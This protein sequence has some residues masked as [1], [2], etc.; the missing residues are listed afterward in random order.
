[1]NDPNPSSCPSR[2]S[3][4]M[5]GGFL[6][7][8]K[9]TAMLRLAS[10]LRKRGRCVALITN[11]QSINLVDTARIG[12][13]GHKVREITGGCFCCR[14]D[15]LV[16]ASESLAAEAEPDVIIAEPVGSC[17]DLK[18]TVS[19]PLQQMHGRQYRVAP[20]SVMVDPHRAAAALRL[21]GRPSFTEMVDYIY[22]K[23]LEEAEI[24]VLNKIDAIDAAFRARLRAALSERY[25]SVPLLE[26]SCVRGD[27]LEEWF[28]RM[29]E[30]ELGHSRAMDI[31]YDTYAEGEARLG[32]VNVRATIRCPEQVDPDSLLATLASHI[33]DHVRDCDAEIGHLKLTL[34]PGHGLPPAS[35]SI[36]RNGECVQVTSVCGRPA[37]AGELLVNLRAE[38]DPA[39]L[40]EIVADSLR[41]LSGVL[42][43][44]EESAAFRPGRPTPTHRMA[45]V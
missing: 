16:N 40:H 27:G 6:G 7:A 44:V 20:L 4:V 14:F 21:D 2:I 42:T 33:H 31:D 45:N 41:S 3:Y 36:T 30:G 19:V 23:Q 10:W 8:G 13:A 35:V 25:R 22:L 34:T 17:T 43:S 1:M 39:L 15:A 24:I 37:Q 28:S 29:I 11:D 32:W 26:V 12:A 18:A 38:A 9:T 5:I